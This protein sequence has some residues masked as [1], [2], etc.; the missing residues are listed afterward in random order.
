MSIRRPTSASATSRSRRRA[1]SIGVRVRIRWR[2]GSTTSHTFTFIAATT[3]SSMIQNAMNLRSACSPRT[4]T[5]SHSGAYPTYSMPDV[6]LVGEEVRK[7]VVDLVADRRGC[8]RR[9]GPDRGR[10]PSARPGAE[11]RSAGGG[12]RRRR[13][14]RRCVVARAQMLI[15]GHT[16]CCR[17]PGRDGEVGAGRCTDAGN[18]DVRGDPRAAARDDLFDGRGA[19]G[20][21]STVL[22]D[23]STTPCSV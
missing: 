13:P 5:R 19:R 3:A 18:D 23:S 7:S 12:R 8:G 9:R 2:I 10:S 11:C 4:T 15:D 1:S 6:V 20:I 22:S 14:R 17:Q 21:A 16:V